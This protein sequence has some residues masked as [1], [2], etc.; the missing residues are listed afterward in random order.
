MDAKIVDYGYRSITAIPFPL[1]INKAQRETIEAIPGLGK[2]RTIR[3]LVNRPFRDKDQLRSALD[4]PEIIDDML[5]H[6]T[7]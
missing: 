5:E 1:D 3:I 4:D 2:K 7:F 6:I